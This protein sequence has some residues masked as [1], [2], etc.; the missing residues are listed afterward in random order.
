M[1]NG[2]LLVDDPNMPYINLAGAD[3][4]R[5]AHD[6]DTP[7]LEPGWSVMFVWDVYH[8]RSEMKVWGPFPTYD[9]AM[10]EVRCWLVSQS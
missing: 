3:V 9:E 4:I 6:S 5:I 1:S 8:D 10:Q 2:W 7:E